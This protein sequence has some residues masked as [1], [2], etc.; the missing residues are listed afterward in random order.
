MSLRKLLF[1]IGLIWSI[2]CHLPTAQAQYIR[3]WLVL[4]SLKAYSG[5]KSLKHPYLEDEAEIQAFGGEMMAGRRW[6]LY[7]SPTDILNFLA[8][9]LDFKIK[10]QSVAYTQVFVASPQAQNAQLLVGSDDEVAIWCN[11][12]R[13]H[14]QWVQ[15][16]HQLDQDRIPVKLKAG[17]NRLLFKVVNGAVGWELSARIVAPRP[18]QIQAEN[19]YQ[20]PKNREKIGPLRVPHFEPH[21]QM[22]PAEKSTPLVQ[23]K[24]LLRNEGMRGFKNIAVTIHLNRQP[25]YRLNSIPQ[26]AGGEI[27]AY[28]VRV[29]LPTLDSLMLSRAKAEIHFQSVDGEQ[30]ESLEWIDPVKLLTAIFNPWP[31]NGWQM[32]TENHHY[33]LEKEWVTP[34]ILAGLELTLQIDAGHYR[35]TCSSNGRTLLTNCRGFSGDLSLTKE[36]RRDQVFPLK[37]VLVPDSSVQISTVKPTITT[38]IIPALPGISSYFQDQKY[39]REIFDQELKIPPEFELELYQALRARNSRRLRELLESLQ[40][41]LAPLANQ[42]KSHALWMFGN[43][44]IDMAWLWPSSETIEVCKQTFQS[45]VDNLKRYPNFIFSHGQAQSYWWVERQAPELFE[46]IKKLVKKGQWEI[47]GGTWVEPDLNLSNGESQVRQYL[48]GKRYFK[49]KFGVDVKV[50]WMPDTFGH[51]ATVPQI[52]KKCG[53]ETYV[54]FRPGNSQRFFNW[55]APDGSE[56]L[57]HRPVNWYSSTIIDDQIWKGLWEEEKSFGIQEVAR[58][59]G[60][61][62][63]GGGPTRKDIE[64]INRLAATPVYPNIK[65]G[66][67]HDYYHQIKAVKT[68]SLYRG[69]PFPVVTAEQNFVFP[70]CYTSQA[71]TKWNNRRAEALVTI[72]ES[73]ASLG[74]F[75]KYEYPQAQLAEVWRRL[76]FNQFHDILAGS[77]IASVYVDAQEVYDQAF[78]QT[79][80]ILRQSMENLAANV[81]TQFSDS[82]ALP[83]V[84]F[85]ALNW[86][87]SGPLEV[88]TQLEMGMNTVQ[89]FDSD[90]HAVPIQA[91]ERRGNMLRVLFLA[92]DLPEMGYRVFWLKQISI[93]SESEP[94]LETKSPDQ[95]FELENQA[96]QIVINRKTGA[97]E[98]F[99]AKALER[100]F[101]NNAGGEIQIQA[102]S[103]PSM[104]AWEIGLKGPVTRLRVPA[105]IE[106]VEDG[107][108]RKVIRVEYHYQQSVFVQKYTLYAELPYLEVQVTID[109]LEREKMAK[110]AFPVQISHPIATFEIPFGNISRETNGQEVPAQ[111]WVDLSNPDYGLSLLNDCKYGFDVKGNLLRM[112]VLRAP[113]DPDSLAD[114]G[115]HSF[116]YSL[117]P[118]RGNWQSA[119]IPRAGYNFNYPLVYVFTDMHKGTYPPRWSFFKIKPDNVILAAFKKAEDNDDWVLR[120]V[121][122]HGKSATVELTLPKMAH[123]ISESDLMEWNATKLAQRVYETN[124]PINPY[125]IKT[126]RISF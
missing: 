57:A 122:T 80:L 15:R 10:E 19:P 59:Y 25:I 91:L 22:L 119:Q 31:V 69:A 7:H 53:I 115:Y 6:V 97:I 61:G 72:A 101:F 36:A 73:F 45:A 103:P 23:F 75:F 121:E 85:N 100:N 35:A 124:F 1:R 29:P 16:G 54:F 112:S 79:Q 95:E 66:K 96:L 41:Q 88:T 39:A 21:L 9:A 55:R 33:V 64:T 44:H 108:V 84:V 70:G 89:I 38:Q 83:F 106:I 87:R 32:H 98:K 68:D 12:E 78:N 52:L 94:E 63:H 82:D 110:L 93:E 3:D 74:M 20:I 90:G 43:A 116:S 62:D 47:I 48:Y 42:A 109:W 81:N 113:T 111:K 117:Y 8:P 92:Q 60:V 123:T 118:H 4:G 30:W 11:T 46:E 56:V 34:D 65:M 102:D 28:R 18:V 76:L 27:L 37:I 58:F 67:M 5:E 120:L 105:K 51:P 50:G 114:R 71:K 13:V 99:Y 14:Y 17:W 104:S 40:S 2:G 126:I 77:A 125:E 86:V 24:F 49:E 107:L 26:L